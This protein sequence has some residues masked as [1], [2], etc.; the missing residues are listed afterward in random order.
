MSDASATKETVLN[1]RVQDERAVEEHRA[2]E[3]EPALEPAVLRR[4]AGARQT[5]RRAGLNLIELCI[6]CRQYS[7]TYKDVHYNDFTYNIR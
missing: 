5:P 4:Q 3:R 1:R 6:S 7:N 2:G